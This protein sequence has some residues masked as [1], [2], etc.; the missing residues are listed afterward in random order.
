[1]S[2]RLQ[3][4]LDGEPELTI[5][6]PPAPEKFEYE[7]CWED[8]AY[9]SDQMHAQ[10][11]KIHRARVFKLCT[12]PRMYGSKTFISSGCCSEVL[13]GEAPPPSPKEPVKPDTAGWEDY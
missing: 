1:M 12:H 3:L 5:T 13:R 9:C 2:T 11:S 4:N 6:D 8:C 10:D 7:T